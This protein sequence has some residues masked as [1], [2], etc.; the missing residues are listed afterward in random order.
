MT[1]EKVQ[2]EASVATRDKQV[3]LWSVSNKSSII[4]TLNKWMRE[5]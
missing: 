2:I 5:K 1:N 3:T 4:P